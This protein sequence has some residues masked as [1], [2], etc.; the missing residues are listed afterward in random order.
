MD[1]L[2]RSIANHTSSYFD[3][4][5]LFISPS[6]SKTSNTIILPLPIFL[7]TNFAKNSYINSKQQWLQMDL[8]CPMIRTT[9]RIFK[10]TLAPLTRPITVSWTMDPPQPDNSP[11]SP[12]L[13]TIFNNSSAHLSKRESLVKT[14]GS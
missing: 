3:Q 12:I 8:P 1:V 6:I 2:N 7:I 4:T 10:I 5:S 14:A 13:G 11:I 9:P